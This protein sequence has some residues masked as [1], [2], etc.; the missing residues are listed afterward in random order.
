MPKK[1]N[2]FLTTNKNT[3]STTL[4]RNS[5]LKNTNTSCS[6]MGNLKRIYMNKNVSCG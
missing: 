6:N 3:S 5:I 2:L 1:I 4:F